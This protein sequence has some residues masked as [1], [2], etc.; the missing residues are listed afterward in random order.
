MGLDQSTFNVDN[1]NAIKKMHDAFDFQDLSLQDAKT[2]ILKLNV[3]K[4]FNKNLG[5]SRNSK[6]KL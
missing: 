4:I 1:Y 6:T 5:F 3:K 2:E